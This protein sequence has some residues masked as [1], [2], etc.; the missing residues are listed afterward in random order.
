MKT[1]V[2]NSN[3]WAIKFF[4]TQIEEYDLTAVLQNTETS[5]C[6]D[7]DIRENQT[8]IKVIYQEVVKKTHI[9]YGI[10]KI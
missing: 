2:L 8:I 1:E 10:C 7:E 9:F 3:G 5:L 4:D 6:I